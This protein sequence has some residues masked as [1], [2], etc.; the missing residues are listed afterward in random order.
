VAAVEMT[1]EIADL[2]G[3]VVAEWQRRGFDLHYGVGLAFGY[4]TL[5]VVGF[6][7]R[8][9]YKPVG[10]VVNLAS[11]LCARSEPGQVLLDHATYAE[12]STRFPSAHVANLELKGYG[13]PMKAY[14]LSIT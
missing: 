2:L 5:G 7:G 9:D 13:G 10:G 11:R 1:R 8:Y 12:T 14:S 3:P 6:D 4:A